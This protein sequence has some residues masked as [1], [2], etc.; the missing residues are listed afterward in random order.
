MNYHAVA[1]GPLDLAAGLGFIRETGRA[2]M[3]WISAN[4][5]DDEGK[6]IFNPYVT[7]HAG[8]LDIC[9]VG[10][11]DPEAIAKD[12]VEI[13][14]SIEELGKL[15]PIIAP[16]HDMTIVL[17][18]LSHEKSLELTKRFPEIKAVVG[19][20]RRKG[21]ITPLLSNDAIVMQTAGLGKYLG[22]LSVS[23]A[24]APW[25]IDQTNKLAQLKNHLKS[26]DRQLNQI[27]SGNDKSSQ[28]YR[29]KVLVLKRNKERI[30]TEISS[31]EMA[32]KNETAGLSQSTFHSDIISLIPSLQQD[33]RISAIVGSI[34]DK[35]NRYQTAQAAVKN[36]Q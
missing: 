9:V 8:E 24:H 26:A 18:N 27:N 28:E 3:P 21:N 16:K 20:D 19:A 13:K 30:L 12:A 17:S 14:D 33:R 34:K 15:I 7:V 35:I 4:I 22:V 31:I 36:A 23:W 32:E 1:V 11:T 29:N 6:R 10:I 2:G 25:K 5:Y